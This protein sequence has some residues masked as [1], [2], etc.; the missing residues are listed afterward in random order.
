[1]QTHSCNQYSA[2]IAKLCFDVNTPK[3]SIFLHIKIIQIVAIFVLV[4][5]S[6][7]WLCHINKLLWIRRYAATFHTFYCIK[8]SIHICTPELFC[9][10]TLQPPLEK[11]I[12]FPLKE[13]GIHTSA[14]GCDRHGHLVAHLPITT[15]STETS[16]K[17]S[18]AQLKFW[19]PWQQTSGAAAE[20]FFFWTRNP[21]ICPSLQRLSH[22][23]GSEV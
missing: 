14:H 16:L 4:L 1:M 7:K 8:V 2:S 20:Y 22:K 18:E 15:T 11:H 21:Q 5:W 12:W 3:E 13:L 23:M 19:F 10:S 6:K 9:L 17:L